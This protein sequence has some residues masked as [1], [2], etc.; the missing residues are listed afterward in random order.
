MRLSLRKNSLTS[1]FKEVTGFSRNLIFRV[2]GQVQGKRH[3]RQMGQ[4]VFFG[5]GGG[6]SIGW[7][8][9]SLRGEGGGGRGGRTWACGEGGKS[10]LVADSATAIGAEIW[11]GTEP[12]KIELSE[13]GGSLNGPDI[14]TELPFLWIFSYQSLLSLNAFPQSVER[15]FFSLISVSSYPLPQ[16]SFQRILISVK[17]PCYYHH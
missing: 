3:P 1:L 11:E 14:F 13:S 4:V 12:R 2:Q 10:F 8:V 6:I 15:R 5:W 9:T 17:C 16:T 7:G